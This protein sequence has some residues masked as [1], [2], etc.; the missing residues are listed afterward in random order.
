MI[1]FKKGWCFMMADVNI[2]VDDT[3]KRE[4]E[5]IFLEL[6]LSLS[7]ATNA[8][9]RQ[10]V[11]HGG[12]PFALRTE[13]LKEKSARKRLTIETVFEGWNGGNPEPY[14]WGEL[15]APVGRELL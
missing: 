14:D 8:F 15:D 6:G 12:I 11:R 5:G 7:T 4:A 9:Y 1:L 2:R 10:V 13:L 3:L